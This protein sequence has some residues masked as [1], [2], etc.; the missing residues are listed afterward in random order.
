MPHR[1]HREP[2]PKQQDRRDEDG[3]RADAATRM[4]APTCFAS[5]LP[6]SCLHGKPSSA[7]SSSF[8]SGAATRR[9]IV[10]SSRRAT[11]RCWASSYV[12]SGS[13]SGGG[14]GNGDGFSSGGGR[15]GEGDGSHDGN[16]D[17]GGST[18]ESVIAAMLKSHGMT[19]AD[20]PLDM[21]EAM[22]RG[23][24]TTELLSVYLKNVGGLMGWFVR[25]VKPYRDRLLCD[26]EFLFKLMVQEVIGNG[27]QLAGE[28]V[29]RGKEIY[30]ELEYVFSDLVIGTV[31]EA[32]FVWILTP[33]IPFPAMAKTSSSAVTQYLR[34]LPA[35]MFEPSS[36]LRKFSASQRLASLFYVGAQYFA[37]GVVCGVIGTWITYALITARKAL[38]KSYVQHRPLPAV[39]PNSVGWGAFMGLSSNTRFQAVEGLERI[40]ARALQNRSEA[41]L[42]FVILFL[43]F[44]NNYYGGIQFVQFFRFLGL[45]GTATSEATH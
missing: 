1:G 42:R 36:A 33:C 6:P 29:M 25:N 27:T 31:V 41:F 24:L 26:N 11:V 3:V 15:R 7:A 34:N 45:Q 12:D 9:S 16:G 35:N 20:L 19:A 28:I 37:V 40:A 18:D 22:Q 44:G 17:Q 4:P 43:R 38:D 39:I 21:A 5:G 32:A 10:P 23:I 30:E 13:G 8:S 14:R 2:P